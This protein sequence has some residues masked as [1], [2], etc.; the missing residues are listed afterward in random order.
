VKVFVKG[1]GE[2]SLTSRDF[3]AEGGEGKVFAKGLTGYKIYHEP[4]KAIPAG[5]MAELATISDANVICPLQPIFSGKTS[6]THVGHT[7]RFVSDTWTLCQLF[8]R[9]FREREGLSHEMT[10][11]LV[12]RM[13]TGVDAVHKAGTLLVDL[14]EM[15]FLVSRDFSA[16]YFIDVDSYQTPHFPA[17]AI[18]PS[19]RDWQVQHGDFSEGSDWFSFAIVTFQMFVGIHPYKGKHP[20]IKA[21]EERMKSN[22]SVFNSSV[23]IPKVC[24]PFDVIPDVYRQ[25]YQSVF[26]NG[27]RD[28]PPAELHGTIVV[29]PTVRVIVSG[30][31]L[32]IAELST[33]G[34]EIRAAFHHHG[35][36]VVHAGDA[37]YVDN[38]Q[39][40]TFATPVHVAFTPRDNRPIVATVEDGMLKLFDTVEKKQ[41]SLSVKC[42]EL[43]SHG[44]RVYVRSRDKVCEVTFAEGISQVTAGVT[45]AVNVLEHASRL[46]PGVVLQN[47]LGKPQA[48]LLPKSGTVHQVFLP[49]LIGH[50]VTQARFDRGVL[51]VVANDGT[52]YHRFVFRFDESFSSYDLRKVENVD[53]AD[54]DFIVLDSGVCVC[55][56]EQEHLEVFSARKGSASVKIVEDPALGGDMSLVN[57]SSRV[58]FHRG[59]KLYSMKLK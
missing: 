17:T 1:D 34:A 5:K 13:Q 31:K 14:N 18:M 26:E 11:K 43:A 25:W 59:N 35:R 40:G 50:R 4:T 23:S 38:R 47:L 22:V 45:L 12:R 16:P 33:F 10:L 20:T 30:D 24:Y 57:D 46:F 41:L 15:N 36:S 53:L 48:S 32:T 39:V 51:M 28:P 8:P 44:G 3:V 55:L 54:L 52:S 6:T 21:L 42:D 37:V 49:E 29:R 19:V 9:A 58:L 27:R 7:F 56:D 2:V